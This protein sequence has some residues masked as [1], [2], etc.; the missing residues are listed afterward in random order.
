MTMATT[1]P[2][3]L[4]QLILSH[5]DT[6]TYLSARQVCRRWHHV[7]STP[8]V[9]REALAK[10]PSSI[11][12]SSSSSAGLPPLNTLDEQSWSKLFANTCRKNLV[13]YWRRAHKR[14]TRQCSTSRTKPVT[15]TTAD[16]RKTAVLS[17]SQVTIHHH[18]T[19]TRFAFLLTQSLSQLWPNISRTLFDSAAVGAGAGV[20]D[21]DQEHAKHRL[22]VATDANLVAVALGKTIQV[23]EY[24]GP[25][26]GPVQDPAEYV[27]GQ[28]AGA[29]TSFISSI[30]RLGPNYHETDG[31]VDSL[32]F[33]ES[34]TLLRV[35]IGKE[36]NVNRST[37]VRYLGDPPSPSPMQTPG[38]GLAYWRRT[39]NRVY[40]DTVA[41]A[42]NLPNN[43]YKTAFKGLRLLPATEE[44]S[45]RC[46]VAAL[47]TQDTQG[48]CIGSIS[49]ASKVTVLHNLPSKPASALSSHK[50]TNSSD[51]LNCAS[52]SRWDPVHLPSANVQSPLLCTSEDNRILAVY[53]PGAGHSYR[54]L[55]GGSVYVYCLDRVD[56]GIPDVNAWSFLVDITNVDIETLGVRSLNRGFK[57]VA[58]SVGGL[59]EMQWTFGH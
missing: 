3:E 31:I 16:G 14:T 12:P 32:E 6:Q 21:M 50:R 37:R 51:A 22:A 15:A 11:F 26:L 13:R 25:A 41:L 43:D 27:L 40:L 8:F 18:D 58:G 49:P 5:A 46:F 44:D 56:E 2:T 4:L 23:Y 42:T 38:P 39:L 29:T 59:E 20:G 19:N 30:C 54:Y 17:G 1:L 47:Q 9:L 48:Y 33:V 45:S 7:S 28:N 36:S 34:D 57:V 55:G 53:E 24:G 10:L 35:A 52:L